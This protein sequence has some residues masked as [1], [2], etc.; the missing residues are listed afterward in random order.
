MLTTASGL[1]L[2]D[3]AHGPD[4]RKQTQHTSHACTAAR[5]LHTRSP[6]QH[7]RSR[8]TVGSNPCA[9][10][11]HRHI[12]KTGLMAAVLPRLIECPAAA[13]AKLPAA[14][15]WKTRITL[16]ENGR[17]LPSPDKPQDVS[18]VATAS[19]PPV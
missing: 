15:T 12:K 11:V 16:T 3:T 14:K 5:V 17:E 10:R 1:A 13:E 9:C 6:A 8:G 7:V 18:W 4:T 19:P 2:V